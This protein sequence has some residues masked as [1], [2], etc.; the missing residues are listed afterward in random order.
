[1]ALAVRGK[2]KTV[3]PTKGGTWIA[4]KSVSPAPKDGRFWLAKTHNNYQA[5][6]SVIITAAVNRYDLQV[7]TEKNFVSGTVKPLVQYVTMDF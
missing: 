7:R 5:L 2:V 4:L 3:Y 6:L 1:M